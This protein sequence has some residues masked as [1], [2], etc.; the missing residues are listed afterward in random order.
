[1]K[2]SRRANATKRSG[3]GPHTTS[4]THVQ[5]SDPDDL[6]Y[7][8]TASTVRLEMFADGDGEESP[9]SFATIK[10]HAANGEPLKF[11]AELEKWLASRSAGAIV[12]YDHH[13]NQ[14]RPGGQ[15]RID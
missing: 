10:V 5:R 11:R 6:S 4:I 15:N 2:P 9:V 1:M 12:V 3:R 8:E 7:I 14:V 13:G